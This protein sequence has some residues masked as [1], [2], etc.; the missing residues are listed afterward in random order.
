MRRTAFWAR[1]HKRFGEA[2]AESLA[3]DLVISGLGSRTVREALDAGV[4]PGEVWAALCEFEGIP[5][6]ERH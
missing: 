4:D 1:M 5:V 6:R 3:R 2:Y